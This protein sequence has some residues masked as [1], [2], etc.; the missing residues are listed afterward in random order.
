MEGSR[1]GS[2]RVQPRVKLSPKP[3]KAEGPDSGTKAKGGTGTIRD[4]KDIP[5]GETRARLEILGKKHLIHS[6]N[7]GIGVS[8][9][10]VHKGP[11]VVGPDMKRD[12]SV[13]TLLAPRKWRD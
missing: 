6:D 1:A 2:R 3:R 9:P 12:W 10:R 5:S 4:I 13:K 7:H 11:V 8:D